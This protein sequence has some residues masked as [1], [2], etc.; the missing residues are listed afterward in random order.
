MENPS[1]GATKSG[2]GV[3]SGWICSAGSVVVTVDGTAIQTG[4]GTERTDTAGVCGDSH[5]GFAAL[6][7][8][9]R[10]GDGA[11]TAIAYADG[12]EFARSNFTVTTLG[13]EFLTGLNSTFL[14]PGFPFAGRT[15]TVYWVESEQNFAI[16]KVE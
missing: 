15:T 12:V 6:Y 9:N 10:F 14:V 2:I 13:A 4:Y 3:I 16:R 1:P 8:W 5:N 7:N 11:H